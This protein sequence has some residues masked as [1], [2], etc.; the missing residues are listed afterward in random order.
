[1]THVQQLEQQIAEWQRKLTE[2]EQ[3]KTVAVNLAVAGDTD[4][5]GRMFQESSVGAQVAQVAIE[6]LKAQRSKA[7]ARDE[8]ERANKLGAEADEIEQQAAPILS[9]VEGL[10]EQAEHL[11]CSLVR[12]GR[13]RDAE[14]YGLARDKR[15]EA[16][17]LR[18]KALEVLGG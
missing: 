16:A 4:S 14:L 3:A 5:A 11:G 15:S 13:Q 12:R 17:Q 10:I 18:L 1:M 7:Q 9:R 6:Q 2:H 8:L